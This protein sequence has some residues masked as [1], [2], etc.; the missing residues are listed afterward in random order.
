M[1]RLD[2]LPTELLDRVLGM[3]LSIRSSPPSISLIPLL[4]FYR[5][6]LFPR[7][8]HTSERS[9]IPRIDEQTTMSTWDWCAI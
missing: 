2:Q 4:P 1:A 3:L 9:R 8:S 6:S 7:L 5:F